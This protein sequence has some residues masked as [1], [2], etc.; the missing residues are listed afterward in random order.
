MKTG[1]DNQ[2][3]SN[4]NFFKNLFADDKSLRIAIHGVAIVL[5]F[6][7]VVNLAMNVKSAVVN[8]KKL[9]GMNS[10]IEQNN[11]QKTDVIESES[12]EPL[13]KDTITDY[14][15]KVNDSAKIIANA[16]TR[17]QNDSKSFIEADDGSVVSPLYDELSQYIKTKNLANIWVDLRVPYRIEYV[18]SDL[19]IATNTSHVTFLVLSEAVTSDNIEDTVID[20]SDVNNSE[21]SVDSSEDAVVNAVE[22]ESVDADLPLALITAEFDSN[23]L[24]SDCQVSLTYLGQQYA[25]VY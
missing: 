21:S 22:V 13:S 2:K 24:M 3:K 20:T 12:V 18:V 5:S 1:Y 25:N 16:Q 10:F 8:I 15:D 4:T 7:L 14:L 19:S 17:I 6:I 9:H 23:G 11:I